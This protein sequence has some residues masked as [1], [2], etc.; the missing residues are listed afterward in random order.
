M[1]GTKARGAPARDCPGSAGT[2]AVPVPCL[3]RWTGASE[4]AGGQAGRARRGASPGDSPDRWGQRSA[5]AA[6]KGWDCLGPPRG[7]G[8]RSGAGERL[9]E[10]SR[11]WSAGT[12]ERGAGQRAAWLVPSRECLEQAKARSS[13]GQAEAGGAPQGEHRELIQ[14][15]DGPPSNSPSGLQISGLTPPPDWLL[16]LC[17]G[18]PS[19]VAHWT[20]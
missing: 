4:T 9:A 13:S 6:G 15:T 5:Q 3:S 20:T 7:S 17:L 2:P 12:P 1:G 19:P 16:R 14:E 8:L 11:A 10:F 18:G